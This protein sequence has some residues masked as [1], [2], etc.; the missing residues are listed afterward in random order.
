MAR[1]R[2]LV[3]HPAHSQHPLAVRNA[4]FHIDGVNGRVVC[5]GGWR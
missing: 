2:R 1:V 5:I 4:T 3:S